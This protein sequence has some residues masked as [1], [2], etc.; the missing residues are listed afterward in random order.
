VV[1]VGEGRPVR[2]RDL[3]VVEIEPV[4]GLGGEQVGVTGGSALER[5]ER[6]ED[7]E[8]VQVVEG[9]DA[10]GAPEQ[11]ASIAARCP[12][13]SRRIPVMRNPESTKKMS[14]PEPPRSVSLKIA[15]SSGPTRAW[16]SPK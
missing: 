14:T 10:Q 4:P 11:E 12:L 16:C 15:F 2:R 3:P 1:D 6:D 13:V 5:P 7:E 8:Q 9:K